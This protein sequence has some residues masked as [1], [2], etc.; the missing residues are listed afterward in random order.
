MPNSSP[1]FPYIDYNAQAVTIKRLRKLS[2]L[3]DTVITIP[4]DRKSVV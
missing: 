4:G 2:R 3:L 1:K